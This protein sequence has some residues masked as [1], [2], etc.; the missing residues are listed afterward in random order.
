MK[1]RL[2]LLLFFSLFGFSAQFLAE[3]KFTG[4]EKMMN[5][6]EM[7]EA[8]LNKLS[9][10]ELRYLN[11]WLRV[12]LANEKKITV[13][14]VKESIPARAMIEKTPD[15][16]VSRIQGEFRGWNGSTVFQLTNGQI[17]KQRQNAKLVYK[18]KNPKIQ[19]RKN[20]MGFYI[21]NIVGTSYS[22][23]VKRIN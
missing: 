4:V 17:W 23:G 13:N 2:I 3:D 11:Q 15:K 21:L 8:G 9:Q 1:T 7:K 16:I 14:K 19:I 10:T 12:Y 6:A 20:F 22:I 5:P 18:A